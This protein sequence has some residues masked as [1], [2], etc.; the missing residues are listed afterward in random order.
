MSKKY[1]LL[2]DRQLDRQLRFILL[3][4]S[5]LLAIFCFRSASYGGETGEAKQQKTTA[6]QGKS[7]GKKI[8]NSIG[9]QFVRIEPGT[10]MMGS[11]A[12][13]KGRDADEEQVRVILTKVFFIQTTEVTQGQWKAI[14]GRNIS[15]FKACGDNCPVEMVSFEDCQKF[16]KKLNESEGTDKYRLPTEAEWE[17]ACRAGTTTVF[18]SGDCLSAGAANYDGSQ[19]LEGCP[20]GG[21]QSTAKSQTVAVA[22][23]APNAWGLYDMHGNVAEWCKDIY[24]SYYPQGVVQDPAGPSNGPIRVVRG[25]EWRSGAAMCRSASRH[26]YSPDQWNNRIGFRLAMTP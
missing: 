10:F 8:S 14:M 9:M 5:L 15:D 2:I 7:D 19:Q 3:A 26:Y 20:P 22:S 18:A 12:N 24:E 25:G 13:E 11:P 4:T 6:T 1:R 17:Y 23:F 16:I 21:T